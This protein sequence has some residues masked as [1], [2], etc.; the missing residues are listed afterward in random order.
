M[1]NAIKISVD[2]PC[3]ENF[4][5]FSKTTSGGFC[6]SCEKE[7]I[8]FTVMTS[9]EIQNHFST[10]ANTTCGRFKSSQLKTFEAMTNNMNSNFVSRGIAIMSFSLLALCSSPILAQDTASNETPV[11]TE[12]RVVP[13]SIVMGKIAIKKY[14]VTG[15]VLDDVN[16]PLGGVNVVLK[17]STIGAVTDFDGRFE[18]PQALDIDDTLVFSYIGYETKEYTVTASE[19]NPIDIT[20]AFEA[21]DITLM[22]DVV[23]GD[24]VYESKSNIFKK[25][26]GI[27]K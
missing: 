12:V 5:N 10:S 7:V 8:D 17:G 15:T 18:F 27:F 2:N 4:E 9:E 11:K 24:E 25:I 14:T 23:V 16:Q 3:S 19:S 21:S 1:K 22:G 6:G 26:I 13:H 20:I